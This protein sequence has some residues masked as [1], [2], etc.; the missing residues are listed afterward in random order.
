[1]GGGEVKRNMPR[2]EVVQ[3]EDPTIRYIA[4]T[5]GKNAIVDATDYDC[6]NEQNW[7]MNAGYAAFRD[8]NRC[9]LMHRLL[10]NFPEGMEIDH[11]NGNRLDNRR[12]NLRICSHM[13]NLANRGKNS[14]NTSGFKGVTFDKKKKLYVAQLKRDSKNVFLGYS[15]TPEGAALIRRTA[16]I[17]HF[18]EFA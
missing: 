16:E 4:L 10:L 15:A 18:G 6:L 3:P 1:M 2:H 13:E 14:N 9:V 12:A 17:Q 5:R 11:I 8:G 7:S